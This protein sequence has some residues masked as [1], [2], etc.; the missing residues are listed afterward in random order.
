[1]AFE[2]HGIVVL[3]AY[4]SIQSINLSSTLD[5]NAASKQDKAAKRL[6]SNI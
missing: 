5:G 6:L 3:N 1:M 4:S 2:L